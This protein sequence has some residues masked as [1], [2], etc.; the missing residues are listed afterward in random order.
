MRRIRLRT[1][2]AIGAL[3]G[4]VGTAIYA[5]T[6]PLATMITDTAS[7][8]Q[9]AALDST[10][11]AGLNLQALTVEGRGQTN[12]DDLLAALD[13]ERGAPI[14]SIDVANARDAIES[15]PWVRTAKVERRLPGGVH[16]IL[17]EYEPYAL[18]Q[19]GERYTL[20]NRTGI[21]IVDVPRTDRSLPLIVGP[22]APQYASAFFDTVNAT[23]PDLAARIVAAVRISGRRWNVH[24]DDYE[25]GIAVRLPEDDLAMSWTRLADI[26]REYKILE[27]DLAFIDL[28]V[29][30]QLIVR[31][32]EHTE[33][34]TSPA[35]SPAAPEEI[36]LPNL[37]EQ[38]EI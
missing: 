21:E 24:F 29:D 25:N 16:V 9:V 12:R 31:I 11:T 15:L 4:A 18:W 2:L 30:G 3:T 36:T 13:L 22:D 38:R 32:N 35:K 5:G 8:L 23:N 10:T 20:V 34:S 14:L 19:R 26:E 27:R 1:I 28:R 37:S 7:N 6:G 33:V 17:K